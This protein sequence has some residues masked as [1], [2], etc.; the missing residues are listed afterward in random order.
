MSVP[1][2]GS[3]YLCSPSQFSGAVEL[4]AKWQVF[5][6]HWSNFFLLAGAIPATCVAAPS[7]LAKSRLLKLGVVALAACTSITPSILPVTSADAIKPSTPGFGFAMAAVLLGMFNL[8]LHAK[9][10]SSKNQSVNARRIARFARYLFLGSGLSFFIA[11]SLK[12][13]A[14]VPGSIVPFVILLG[15]FILFDRV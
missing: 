15:V 10:L 14:Y 3:V 6:R 11:M 12:I 1:S 7:V 4:I 13:S 5:D 8:I 2:H 9:V